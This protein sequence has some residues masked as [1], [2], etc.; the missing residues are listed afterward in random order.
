MNVIRG[1]AELEGELLHALAKRV[2]RVEPVLARDHRL[3]VVQP[4]RCAREICVGLV[5][6]C[7]QE[8]GIARKRRRR[9]RAPRAADLSP[10]A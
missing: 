10:A 1:G 4:E 5:R 7:R 9:G 6:E 8:C 3:R 2:P